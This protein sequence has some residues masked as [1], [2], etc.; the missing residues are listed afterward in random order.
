MKTNHTVE[1]KERSKGRTFYKCDQ[2]LYQTHVK[3]RLES[4]TNHKHI[5]EKDYNDCDYC[6]YRTPFLSRMKRH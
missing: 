4:H 5:T 3:E 2:C 1:K 6:D